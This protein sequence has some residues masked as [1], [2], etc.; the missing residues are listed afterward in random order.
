MMIFL[1]G[2][3]VVLIVILS[4]CLC[5]CRCKMYPDMAEQQVTTTAKTLVMG[6]APSSKGY[7]YMHA[8]SSLSRFLYSSAFLAPSI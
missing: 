5:V 3:F 4:I 6:V 1:A 7:V 8:P 2:L